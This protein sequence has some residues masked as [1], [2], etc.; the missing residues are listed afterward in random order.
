MKEDKENDKRIHNQGFFDAC[1]NAVNGIIYGTTTQSNVKTQL[2]ISA[3]L[4]LISLFFNL[5]K[6]EFLCLI[7]SVVL[8][9]F[10][11]MVNTAIE[12][13]V[14]LYTDLYHPKAKIAKDV[15]AGAVLVCSINSVVIAIVVFAER[16]LALI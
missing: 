10:A 8:I 3:F 6:V 15:G 1:K 14:D 16:I 13:V 4:I 5:T 7:I 2:V 11:E 12:T 9:I